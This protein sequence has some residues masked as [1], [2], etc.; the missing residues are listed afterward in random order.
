MLAMP[1]SRS[2][3]VVLVLDE[4]RLKST[5]FVKSQVVTPAPKVVGCENGHQVG[6]EQIVQKL[7]HT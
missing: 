1:R 4:N 6:M 2:H 5:D 7:G 3:F